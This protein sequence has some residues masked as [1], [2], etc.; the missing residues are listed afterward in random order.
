MA[1]D[2]PTLV[3]NEIIPVVEGIFNVWILG[4]IDALVQSTGQSLAFVLISCAIEYLAGFWKGG[5]TNQTDYINFLSEYTEFSLKYTPKD[6]YKSLRCGLV[7]NFT[8]HNGVY[9]LTFADTRNHLRKSKTGHII[10]NFEN[11]Y[12]DFKKLKEAFFTR[13]KTDNAA[14]TRFIARFRDKGFLVYANIPL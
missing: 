5:P 6:V 12:L 2:E 11:F 13:A 3:D 14:K 1:I 9:C 4:G 8:I 10:L 7:H